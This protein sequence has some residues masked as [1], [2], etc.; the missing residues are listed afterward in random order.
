MAVGNEDQENTKLGDKNGK[1][2]KTCKH[3]GVTLNKS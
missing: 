3:S 1:G 2:V